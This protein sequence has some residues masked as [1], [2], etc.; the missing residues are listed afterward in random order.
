MRS[1]ISVWD[2][3]AEQG[4]RFQFSFS[5]EARLAGMRTGY[6]A[7]TR[8]FLLFRALTDLSVWGDRAKQLFHFQ[9]SISEARPAGMRIGCVYSQF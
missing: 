5:E 8:T 3:R 9:L 1:L 6:G 7:A 4:F 2:D